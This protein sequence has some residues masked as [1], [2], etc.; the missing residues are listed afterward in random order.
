MLVSYEASG[1]GVLGEVRVGQKLLSLL[2]SRTLLG[3]LEGWFFILAG[4]GKG[5][6]LVEMTMIMMMTLLS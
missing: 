4:G 1:G 5:V 3:Q 6:M 2:L